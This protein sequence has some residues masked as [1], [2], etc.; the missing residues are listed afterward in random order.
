MRKINQHIEI[1]ASTVAG[2]S[3]MS[4]KSRLAVLAALKRHYAHVGITIVNN[5]RDLE[6]LVANPPDLVFLG[7]KFI[8]N[9]TKIGRQDPNRI[10][11]SEYLD[12]CG[13]AYTGS[14]QAAHQLELDKSLAKQRMVEAGLNT[15]PFVVARHNK[16]LSRHEITPAFPVFIKPT[17]RGGGVGVDSASLARRYR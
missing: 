4:H 6:A 9:D 3:S 15:S 17:D 7:M 16:P 8:P 14:N 11:L 2:L 5:L 1:V 13:I 10:W 12:S